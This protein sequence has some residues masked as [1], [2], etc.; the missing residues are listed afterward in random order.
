[1]HF[2]ILLFAVAANAQDF[3]PFKLSI[4]LGYAVLSDGGG[5]ILFEV[6][7]A[8]RLSDE[9]ALGLRLG[10]AVMAKAIGENEASASGQASYTVNAQYY[11]SNN[12]FRPYI[13]A[14]VGI[15]SIAS[16]AVSGTGSSTAVAGE[17]K[18]G[19]YPRIGFDLGHFNVNIDYNLVS[20][21]DAQ[22]F[23]SG[24]T[25]EVK[26]SYIGIRIG[27]YFFGGRN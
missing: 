5:G 6:E 14:G 12:T 26:N 21:S 9:I 10:S 17:S 13:G 7:P 16:A 20:A 19:F 22:D 15:F 27:G 18:I 8:Y 24:E 4:G 1:M 23:N 25:I 3:K 2:A 11:L